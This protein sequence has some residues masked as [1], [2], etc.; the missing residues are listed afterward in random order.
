VIAVL[1]GAGLAAGLLFILFAP[2]STLTSLAAAMGTEDRARNLPIYFK[3][4]ADLFPFGSGMGSFDGIFKAYEPVANLSPSYLNHAHNDYAQVLIEAGLAAAVG[5]IL[6]GI[7]WARGA[8]AYVRDKSAPGDPAHLLDL[9]ALAGT[10][11]FLIHSFGE[12][13]LRAS[14][15]ALIFAILCARIAQSRARAIPV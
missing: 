9:F 14:A 6:F 11:V 13:P 15:N 2:H 12:Y 7:W 5:L 8:L 3:M 10:G 1:V 4:I